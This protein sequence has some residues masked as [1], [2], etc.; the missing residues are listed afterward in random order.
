MKLLT[1]V[2]PTYNMEKYLDN[3]LQSFVDDTHDLFSR[4]EILVVND[5]SVDGSVEIAKKY[6]NQYP[7]IFRLIDKENGGHGSTINTGIKEATG[8]YFRVVDSDDW[9]DTKN[10]YFFLEKLQNIDTDIVFTPYV[11]VDEV[12]GRKKKF[13]YN[14]KGVEKDVVCNIDEFL[15]NRQIKMHTITYRTSILQNNNIHL[16]E[17]C[18]YVDTEYVL[19]PLKYVKSCVLINNAVYMYRVNLSTQSCSNEGYFKHCDDHRKVSLHLLEFICGELKEDLSNCKKRYY[20]GFILKMLEKQYR[21][22]LMDAPL[23]GANR[24]DIISFDICIKE[25][26]RKIYKKIS[27]EPYILELRKRQFRGYVLQKLKFN[28]LQQKGIYLGLDF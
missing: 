1:V 2:I 6:E 22:Y 4:I 16:D 13:M 8:K 5:G 23:S 7:Q 19:F 3:C 17:H 27:R 12:T 26:S 15:K 11:S 14:T 24:E 18:F 21:I 10:F 9:V 20:Y 25:Q 28:W